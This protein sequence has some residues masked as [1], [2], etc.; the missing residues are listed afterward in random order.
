MGMQVL[1]GKRVAIRETREMIGKPR[2][3]SCILTPQEIFDTLSYSKTV[4]FIEVFLGR[5]S[6]LIEF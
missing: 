1:H 4:I 5:Y 6:T 3:D 2:G